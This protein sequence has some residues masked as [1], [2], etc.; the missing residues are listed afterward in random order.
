L[1]IVALNTFFSLF[2][3]EQSQK[4]ISKWNLFRPC[5]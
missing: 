3:P 1:T 5:H 4:M 2:Y